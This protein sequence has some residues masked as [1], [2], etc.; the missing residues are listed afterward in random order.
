ML[1]I[2]KIAIKNTAELFEKALN[3]AHSFGFT[4]LEETLKNMPSKRLKAAQ[5]VVHALPREKTFLPTMRKL[6]SKNAHKHTDH[7]LGYNLGKSQTSKDSISLHVAGT[8]NP[9]AEATLIATAFTLF[10]D[11]GIKDATVHIN[12]IGTT[13]S[14]T[15][16]MRD[17][18]K[19]FKKILKDTPL[20]VRS[21]LAISPLRAYARLC[22]T[23]KEL[24]NGCPNAIDYLNDD[25]RSHL[26][27]LL[28]YLESSGIPYVLDN[29]VVGGGD[30]FEQTLFE[31]KGFT[32]EKGGDGTNDQPELLAYGGRYSTLGRRAF[33]THIPTVGL[34]IDILGKG[35]SKPK[36]L[37]KSRPKFYFAQLGVNAKKLGLKVLQMLH[38][39]GI[40]IGH[41]LT[42]EELTK[43][44]SYPLAKQVPYV[45]IIG[46]K[47][48]LENTAIV[49]NTNT[50]KQKVVPINALIRYLKKLQK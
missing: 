21:D 12:S 29:T 26:W 47:E 14:F 41:A 17:L 13:E 36:K 34:T 7:I 16:Y 5:K 43:Q 9:L 50:Y 38:K 15:R 23:N 42:Q 4:D 3:V 1:N 11:I 40:K 49:R 24:S 28:E 10:D 6:A 45:I 35:A 18:N 8:E 39:E 48:A 19:Y 32:A 30:Y 37:V 46:Q 33:S 25:G 27:G 44:M 2:K 22:R 31:I 20:Q